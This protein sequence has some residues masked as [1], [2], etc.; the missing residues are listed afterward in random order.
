[1]KKEALI[2]VFIGCLLGLVITFG[3][4]R[5]NQ[6]ISQAGKTTDSQETDTVVEQII[7]V[8]PTPAPQ[9]TSLLTITSPEP[10]ALV[11][12]NRLTVTG[13]SEPQTPVVI[14][15]QEGENII[16]TDSGGN[17]S[18]EISLTGGPNQIDIHGFDSAGNQISKTINVVY[19]TAE[20]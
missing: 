4:R 3:I 8:S 7:Q 13:K 14:L 2:A 1:V 12:Q 5:A 10:N 18:Q 11:S 20:I 9:P 17:F 19:S 15:Y 16:F 6:A